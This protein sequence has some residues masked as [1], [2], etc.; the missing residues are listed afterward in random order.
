MIDPIIKEIRADNK[1][2]AEL[3]GRAGR[4]FCK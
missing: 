2:M 3:A 4:Q 1:Q